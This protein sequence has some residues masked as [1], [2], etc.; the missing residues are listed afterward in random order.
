MS[1]ESEVEA[2]VEEEAPAP[3]V[4]TV[5]SL[6]NLAEVLGQ[7][8]SGQIRRRTVE[9]LL[10]SSTEEDDNLDDIEKIPELIRLWMADKSQFKRNTENY[11]LKLDTYELVGESRDLSDEKKKEVLNTLTELCINVSHRRLSTEQI[12]TILDNL[13]N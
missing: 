4:E 5:Y 9:G 7:W 6:K 8:S 13:Y 10:K 3:V 2:P 1:T 11:L 12:N